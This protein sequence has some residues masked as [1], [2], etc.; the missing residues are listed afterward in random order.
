MVL[1]EVSTMWFDKE[2]CDCDNIEHGQSCADT[3]AGADDWRRLG[4]G[5]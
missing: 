2:I 1:L 4:G 5:E 3:E